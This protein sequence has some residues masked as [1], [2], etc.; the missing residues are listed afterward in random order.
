MPQASVPDDHDWQSRAKPYGRPCGAAYLG[1][2]TDV[3][4]TVSSSSVHCQGSS[5]P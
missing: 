1:P 5:L 4:N 2:T 3:E